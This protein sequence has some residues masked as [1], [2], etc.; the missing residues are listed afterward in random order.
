VVW[1]DWWVER[2]EYDG[3]ERW[4]FKELPIAHISNPKKISTL[5][6]VK[7]HRYVSDIN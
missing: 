7:C 2:E 5:K 3:S 1:D 6:L 4:N